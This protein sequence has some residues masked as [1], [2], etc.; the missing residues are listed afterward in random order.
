M[1]YLLIIF[2]LLVYRC[3]RDG[4]GSNQEQE[5]RGSV[6]VEAVIVT[7][8][9]LNPWIDLS[10]VVSGINEA[11]VVS[12]TEGVIRS[13]DFE[14]GERVSVGRVLLSVDRE[15]ARFAMQQAKQQLSTARMNLEAA[16]RLF[17]DTT[18]SKSEYKE[19]L[20][21]YNGARAQYE[22]A[23]KRY[24]NTQV[25][26]P[27]EGQ[28][29]SKENTI[30]VGNYIT[31]GS[32]IARIANLDRVRFEGF[33]G[34]REIAAI[35]TGAQAFVTIAA[36]EQDT[37]FSAT[38]SEI[39]AGAQP[40]SGSYTVVLTF[41]NPGEDVRSG[42]SANARIRTSD[43]DSV[44]VVPT[45]AL[46]SVADSTFL[47]VARGSVAIRKEIETGRNVNNLT[48]ISNGIVAG[49][50]VIITR[51]TNLSHQ[52]SVRVEVIGES[53]EWK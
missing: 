4:N 44:L 27:I 32:V 45:A 39:A 25:R 30:S 34:E 50:T 8:G 51:T 2:L 41:D 38:V 43:G 26:A 48:E 36:I 15:E 37:L 7:R 52:D 42:M 33:V 22:S 35:E 16:K 40:Q 9:I 11:V 24:H 53:G 29:A 5:R 3:N 18:I 23:Q 1:K 20:G 13:V 47:F 19:A 21:A 46:R 10:G 28:V 6:A 17:E 12:E 49:D 14:L 31:P